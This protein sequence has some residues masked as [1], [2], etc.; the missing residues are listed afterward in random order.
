MDFVPFAY[1]DDKN[2]VCVKTYEFIYSNVARDLSQTVTLPKQITY[3]EPSTIS[4]QM[5]CFVFV[6]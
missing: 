1:E 2:V 5:T 6:F 3:S 4:I